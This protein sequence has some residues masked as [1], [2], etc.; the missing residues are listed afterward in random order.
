[1]RQ[2]K[3]LLYTTI[4]DAMQ[5]ARSAGDMDLHR[6]INKVEKQVRLLEDGHQVPAL[7]SPA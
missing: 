2:L 7:P 4:H 6:L 1:M 3:K 5:L